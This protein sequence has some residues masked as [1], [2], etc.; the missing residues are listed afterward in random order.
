[1]DNKIKT[2]QF[3]VFYGQELN[4]DASGNVK[5]ENHKIAVRNP[6]DLTRFLE[7][8]KYMGFCRVDVEKLF[9]KNEKE[10]N[11]NDTLEEVK[12]MLTEALTVKEDVKTD[13]KKENRELKYRLEQQ[14]KELS[15][16]KN[17]L[18]EKAEKKK[19]GP[20]LN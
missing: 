20:K 4:Y 5:N 3:R 6:E 19:P 9:D 8:L 10:I 15:E 12:E 16:I 18:K 17:M 14:E 2:V 1:M 11:N 13:Y 7:N